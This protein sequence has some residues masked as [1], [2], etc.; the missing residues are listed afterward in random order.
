MRPGDR[1]G[2][3]AVVVPWS[4]ERRGASY[5]VLPATVVATEAR[6]VRVR[7]DEGLELLV[8]R[9]EL[10]PLREPSA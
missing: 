10:A 9:A 5:G 4:A 8:R 6:G 3:L 7:F 2:R 1:V